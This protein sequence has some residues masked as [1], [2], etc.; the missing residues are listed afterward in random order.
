MSMVRAG[1]LDKHCRCVLHLRRM[2]PIIIRDHDQN[3]PA[4]IH[5]VADRASHALRRQAS[6]RIDFQ[7]GRQRIESPRKPDWPA[8]SERRDWLMATA[9]LFLS[10]V[11]LLRPFNVMPTLSRNAPDVDRNGIEIDYCPK[12]RGVWLDRGELQKLIELS[13]AQATTPPV[14]PEPPRRPDPPVPQIDWE[15]SRRYEENGIPS[16]VT[17]ATTD[18]TD[19][20]SIRNASRGWESYSTGIERLIA[21]VSSQMDCGATHRKLLRTPRAG[22]Q[23]CSPRFSR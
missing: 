19:T 17:M 13:V 5:R 15:Q 2:T 12:C 23:L 9:C 11:L 22:Y 8:R 1:G 7:N 6:K 18:I 21:S 20:A 3:I 16:V 10:S 14:V 4:M